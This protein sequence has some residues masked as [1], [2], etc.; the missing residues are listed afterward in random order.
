MERGKLCVQSRGPARPPFYKIQCWHEGK[1]E[2]HYVRAEQVVPVQEALA[3]HER[4]KRL[5]REF[6]DLTIAQTRAGYTERKK[7]S[8]RFKPSVF[9]KPEHS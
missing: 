4:F 8:K 2:T 3:G 6:V 7:S 5:V 9:R 1:N